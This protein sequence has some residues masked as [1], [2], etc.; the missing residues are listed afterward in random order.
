MESKVF[1][2]RERKTSRKQVKRQ[3]DLSSHLSECLIF[4]CKFLLPIFVCKQSGRR[5]LV[6]F[7]VMIFFFWGF[8][9]L[10]KK[11]AIDEIVKAASSPDKDHLASFPPFRHY[12]RNGTLINT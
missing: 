8:Q 5:K 11:K 6:F 4:K 10:E 3:N 9:I 12:Q 2:G 1:T 7:L